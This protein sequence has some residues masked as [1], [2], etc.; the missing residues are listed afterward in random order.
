MSLLFLFELW[1]I[2]I[3]FV[4]NSV[5]VDRLSMFVG[6]MIGMVFVFVVFVMLNSDSVG[7]IVVLVYE[8]SRCVLL[9]MVFVGVLV[10]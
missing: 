10:W 7:W 8:Y 4:L 6:L 1:L 5:S 3:V 2:I 9:L